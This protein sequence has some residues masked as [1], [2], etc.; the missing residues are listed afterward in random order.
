MFFKNEKC[1]RVTAYFD[2]R[3]CGW[4]VLKYEKNQTKRNELFVLR[5]RWRL[6]RKHNQTLF[7][8]NE[9]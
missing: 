1:I 5:W 3:G 2:E 9:L 6:R 8:P 4:M 7:Q